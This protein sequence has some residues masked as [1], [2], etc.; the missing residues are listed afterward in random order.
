MRVV[1]AEDSVLLR[2]GSSG[3]SRTRGSRWSAQAGDAE[4]LLRQVASP[5]PDVVIVDI[6][7]P[8]THIDEG[9][10]AAREIRAEFPGSA[11]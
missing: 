3:C 6:R 7:M 5:Q 4:E 9:L 8:P 11:C 1:I 10:Q 2:E